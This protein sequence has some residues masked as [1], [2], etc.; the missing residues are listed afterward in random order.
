MNATNPVLDQFSRSLVDANSVMIWIAGDDARSIHFNPAWLK[1]RGRS[2]DEEIASDWMAGVFPEDLQRVIAI[3]RHSFETRQPFEMKYR[4]LDGQGTFRCVESKGSLWFD[5]FARFRGF[6]VSTIEIS[7]ESSTN[8]AQSYEASMTQTDLNQFS[9][10]ID[11][12]KE[13]AIFVLN[14]DGI[15]Q[16]WNSG[17]ER[18]KGYR[19]EEII[20]QHFSIFYTEEDRQ[21]G[22]P[23]A[24]LAL[25]AAIGRTADE[26]YRVRK[27]G[28]VL[29][30]NVV[31]TALRDKSG[32]LIGFG[33]VTRDL[34]DRKLMEDELRQN[35]AVLDQRI[36]ERTEELVRLN[37]EIRASEE[38]FRLMIECVK[39]Y[40]IYT[41]DPEGRVTS[42]NDG[43]ARIYGYSAAEIVGQHRSRFFAQEEI[44]RGLPDSE[45]KEAADAGR[46]SEEAWRVRKDGSH[47]WANG[48][49]TVR[50]DHQGNVLG[51]VKVVRDLTERKRAEVELRRNLEVIQLRDRAIQA[52]SQGILIKDAHDSNN[53]IIYASPGF[54]KLTGYRADEVTGL[55]SRFLFGPKTDDEAVKHLLKVNQS[56]ESATVEILNYRKSSTPYWASVSV[57]PVNNEQG[58]LVHFVEVHTDITERRILEDQ[59]R[60]SQKMEAIGQLASGVAHDFNNLLTVIFGYGEILLNSL[61]TD[62]PQ[63]ELVSEICHAGERAAGLTRQLL[64][65]SRQNVMELKV[66]S[67]N[68]IVQEAEKLL[69]RIV[70]EDIRLVTIL[71]PNIG[72]VRVDPHHMGQVLLNLAVNA[73]DAMPHG[74]HLTIETKNVE[75]D[76]AYV[77]THVEVKAGRHAVLSVSDNGTGM[78][79][80]VRARIFEPFFTTK[81]AGQ[82]T[83]L[84]LSVV[85]G[86]IRQCNGQIGAYSEPGIGTT[87]KIYLPTVDET[88]ASSPESPAQPSPNV[89]ETVLVVEDEEAVR[90]IAVRT[91]KSQG[92]HVLEAESGKQAMQVVT[93]HAGRIDILVTDVVMPEMSGRQLAE[94]LRARLPDLK[95]LYQ[96]GYTDDAVIRHGILEAEVAFLQKPYTP[97]N[98][99]K[100]VREVLDAGATSS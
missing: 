66:V 68:T 85:H 63:R 72:R 82:G 30:A 53:R 44:A 59:V 65:F 97:M 70:G 41:L 9:L 54:E 75:L 2:F 29:W 60:Q 39:D 7:P 46:F 87:F 86:I 99:I 26:G 34:T 12:V 17:A 45:M 69:R 62:D 40:A 55:N 77:N 81:P 4:L 35:N 14:P 52:V 28:S 57:T 37:E 71:D 19:S 56:H 93:R 76:E 16:T 38:E 47:F 79:P 20:G 18:I 100:K 22:K 73:R 91:L 89:Y 48:T 88:S 25:A 24:E 10:L 5:H 58:E 27:D 95:V 33:K 74:G 92:Y 50:R 49:M 1:F 11:S 3:Y 32:R 96:S 8:A 43:A 83:G 31:I 78:T 98:L 51:F 61:T 84:G 6:T 67:F 64:S 15:I 13:Y 21:S 80:D 36:R 42:W 94:L 90:K 23:A